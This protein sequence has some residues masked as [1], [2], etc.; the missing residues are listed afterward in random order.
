LFNRLSS[1]PRQA[2][3][4]LYVK[5]EIDGDQIDAAKHQTGGGGAARG[6]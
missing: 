5:Q 6:N 1:H 4:F 2:H 3:I